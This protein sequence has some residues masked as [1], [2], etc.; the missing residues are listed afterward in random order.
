[1]SEARTATLLPIAAD[2]GFSPANRGSGPRTSIFPMRRGFVAGLLLSLVW[3]LI[4]PGQVAAQNAATGEPG[5]TGLARVGSTLT[6]NKGN[7]AD[8]D[9]LGDSSFPGDYTFQWIRVDGVSET[10]IASAT[11]RTYS[12]VSA[13]VGK[14]LKVKVSFTDDEGNDESRTSAAFPPPGRSKS[15]RSL[16]RSW[17][18]T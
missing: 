7:I 15:R 6:A 5:I 10:N 18:R 3:L 11:S 1:M 2:D 9:G 14:T 13:D 8:A 16:V 12:P 4:L 17:S